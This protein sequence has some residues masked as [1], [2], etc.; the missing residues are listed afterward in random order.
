MSEKIK[1]RRYSRY[2]KETDY[3]PTATDLLLSGATKMINKCLCGAKVKGVTTFVATW[4]NSIGPNF[5]AVIYH[6]PN[7]EDRLSK[8]YENYW[9]QSHPEAYEWWKS[10]ANLP[11]DYIRQLIIKGNPPEGA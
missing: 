3:Y 2:V 11:L 6:R 10:G 5:R 9:K 8:H 1:F 7:A 4:P